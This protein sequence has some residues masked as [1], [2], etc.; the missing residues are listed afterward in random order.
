LEN[1]QDLAK[2]LGS[3]IKE[4]RKDYGLSQ[5]KLSEDTGL[6][7]SLISRIENGLAMPSI[8][9]LQ[10]IANSL[11]VD[12]GYFFKGE[13]PRQFVISPKTRRRTTVSGKGYYNIEILVEG[14]ETAFMEPAIVTNVGR[15]QEHD[16]ESS[17]H[18]GQEFMYVL[19][20]K[21]ELTLGIKKHILEKGDA[22]YWNGNIPHKGIS[23][24]KRPA[25]SLNVHFIP[26]RRIGTFNTK[27]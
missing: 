27:D 8:A 23:L 3:R 5:K 10:S 6:S 4:I 12:I 26:G 11:K 15:D 7:I 21:I 17:V 1:K 9:T 2:R 14:M 22:A 16:V 25:K 18:D 24:S 20:G 19:E 13:K